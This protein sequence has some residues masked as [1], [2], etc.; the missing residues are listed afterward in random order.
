MPYWLRSVATLSFWRYALFSA[1]AV[2]KILA[3]LGALYLLMEI[4]DFLGIYTKDKYSHFA[5]IPL[6]LVAVAYVVVT[7]R[8]VTKISYKLPNKDYCITVRVG[9]LFD[10]NAD[11][12]VSTNTTFDTDMAHGLIAT[13]SVQGQVATR[14]FGS[15]TAEIDKQLEAELATVPFVERVDAP[16]K[17]REYPFGTVARVKGYGRTFYFVA[18]ARLNESGTASTTVR[19][20]EDA[21]GTLWA[22]IRDFG[23]LRD[24][25]IP[26]V[27]TGRGRIG[28]PRK[29]MVER[30]AQSFADASRQ[31]IFS[32]RLSI[33][34]RPEDAENFGVN[35]YEI[36]DYLVQSLHP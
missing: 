22:F 16:G 4:M 6:L 19:D 32:N 10:G 23:E 2:A 27:G 9:D 31:S 28:F 25:A 29:K 17:P 11:V 8:P 3:T 14:F 35:L 34:V 1:E 26:L 21:L 30:I 12:V 5:V 15:N 36:R 18:M 7:R 13:D 20:V 24:V 33:V